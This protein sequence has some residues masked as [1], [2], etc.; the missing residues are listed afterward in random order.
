LVRSLNPMYASVVVDRVTKLASGARYVVYVSGENAKWCENAGRYHNSSRAYFEI[1]VSGIRT[2]C[3]CRKQD[4]KG[5]KFGPCPKYETGW[6]PLP[7]H[8]RA[9]LFPNKGPAVEFARVL[10]RRRDKVGLVDR[11][12]TQAKN[13]LT[14]GNYV[15]SSAESSTAGSTRGSASNSAGHSRRAS[16]SA[17]AQHQLDSG[18]VCRRL[19]KVPSVR[20]R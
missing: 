12:S 14:F 4:L 2:K 11:Y 16:M 7:P 6:T 5:R 10:K 1:R 17:P 3:G 9:T 19:A 13:E 8:L 15:K 18:E 20:K